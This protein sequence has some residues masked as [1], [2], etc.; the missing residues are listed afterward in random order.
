MPAVAIPRQSSG[1]RSGT[2]GRNVSGGSLAGKQDGDWRWA[3]DD[4]VGCAEAA[5]FRITAKDHDRVG[6]L[7]RRQE[8]VSTRVEAETARALPLRRLMPDQRQP[9]AAGRED[10]DA[11]VA[12]VRCVD[13]ATIRRDDDLRP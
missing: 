12:A 13:E 11:V 5:G 9:I 3:V 4:L 6:A 10:R 8:P 1:N 7:V 2:I